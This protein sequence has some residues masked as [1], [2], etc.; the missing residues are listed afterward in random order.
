[1]AVRMPDPN[2][3]VIEDAI[4]DVINALKQLSFRKD[5]IVLVGGAPLNAQSARAAGADVYCNDISVAVE[6]AKTLTAKGK[7]RRVV[8]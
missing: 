6:A 5:C 1:M 3:T 8:A 4:K 7:K 2:D